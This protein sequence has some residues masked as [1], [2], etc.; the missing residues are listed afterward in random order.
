VTPSLA[1]CD[2]TVA[3]FIVTV[4]PVA[5]VYFNPNG[6]TLCSGSS[7]GISV[8]SHV[9]GALLP[10]IAVA[11]SP[12]VS[13][14]SNG[15]GSSITQ[16]L[17][18][19]AT[20]PE[21]VTYTVSPSFTGCAGIPNSVI[22]TV[23]P[24]P[25]T[26]YTVCNDAI[27]TTAAQPFKLKGG[28]PPG[29]TYTGVGVN[30]I[31][32]IFTPATA[33]PGNHIITYTSSNTWGCSAIAT[34]TISVV[35]PAAFIC[36][37]SITDIRDNKQYPT[38]KIGAQCWMATNLN[39]GSYIVSSLQ[40]QRDNCI[41]E[42]FCYGENQANCTSYGGLY[43]WDEI[44][45]YDINAAGQGLCLPG[46]HV[47]TENDW[48]ALFN[49]YTSNGFAGSPLK[50]TGYSGFNAFLSGALFNNENWNFTA[51][52][53]MFW[54]STTE[55]TGKAWAHGM[56]SFNPSVSYYPS[57]KTNAFSVRCIHD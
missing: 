39:Y 14:Y 34:Q 20:S 2:G 10:W 5:D 29:G 48:T 19:T 49:F 52:A 18:S 51:F 33:G 3:H 46:W 13:G 28:L 11:S 21:T 40:M 43:Q 24:L 31:T 12:L 54:S 8:L 30:S 38:V 26:S 16:P 42:K 27:T 56:N 57:S 35:N 7:T 23:D 9:A 50:Y 45:R 6:Q 1:G 55:G 15:A 53:V 4:N 25:A 17:T 22:V 41:P 36:D 47:P 32:G 37:N 44:M